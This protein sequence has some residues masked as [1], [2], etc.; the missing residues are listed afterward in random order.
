MIVMAGSMLVGLGKGGIVGVG[1]LTVILFAMVFEAKASVGLL[2]PVLISADIVAITVYR[3]H[4]DWKQ[5]R[6]LLPWMFAGILVGYFLFGQMSNLVVRRLIGGIV[7]FMTLLQIWRSY[8]ARTGS[9]D[10]AERMP[11][12]IGWRAVLGLLGGFA[13]MMA[14]A[15]G[16][17]GQL[18]FISVGLPKMAFI[19]T[20]AWCFFIVNVFK[21]PLQAHLGIINLDSLQISLALAPFAMLGAWVAPKIVHLIPQKVFTFA[22]WFFIVLAGVKLTFF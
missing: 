2:L 3:R 14:N 1:N 22:V 4:A 20:G 18:Y 5:L 15:A 16:P 6:R 10:L 12:T 13:T 7:L 8:A 21:V 11:H 19:G 9:T 17:V